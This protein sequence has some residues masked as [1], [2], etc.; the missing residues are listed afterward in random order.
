MI[1]LRKE[2]QDEVIKGVMLEAFAE[3]LQSTCVVGL[4]SEGTKYLMWVDPLESV[5]KRKIVAEV[6]PY[7][8]EAENIV[9][10]IIDCRAIA[11]MTGAEI[12]A[13]L[14][15]TCEFYRQVEEQEITGTIAEAIRSGS[16]K[17]DE[18]EIK[19]TDPPDESR[20]TEALA[21]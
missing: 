18:I 19:L 17:T 13:A 12:D 9:R 1:M 8:K 3:W 16:V 2:F 4:K 10:A 21:G 11:E 5:R 6:F 7:T 14:T 20:I 15:M